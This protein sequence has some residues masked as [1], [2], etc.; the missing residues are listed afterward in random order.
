TWLWLGKVERAIKLLQELSQESIKNHKELKNLI[1]YLDRN[2]NYIPC[3]A[4]RKKLGL[5]LS[6]N[7]VEK[8]ND[9]VVSNRQKH[10]GMSW[11]ADGSSSLARLPSLRRN[12][13]HMH[14]LRHHDIRFSFSQPKQAT[15][16]AKLA[17]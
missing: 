14:W 16:T 15:S 1:T 4:L 13:E 11:S 5:R 8:A 10:N 6:S 9:L 17:A 12:D 2:S 3:Y 7:P